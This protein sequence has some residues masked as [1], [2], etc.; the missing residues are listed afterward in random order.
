MLFVAARRMWSVRA[1]V[2]QATAPIWLP[3]S[4]SYLQLSLI[5]RV[6]F[7]VVVCCRRL[8][9]SSTTPCGAGT[10]SCG[11]SI[12]PT[13]SVPLIISIIH[14]ALARCRRV[15]ARA[16]ANVQSFQQ[17]VLLLLLLL[18]LDVINLIV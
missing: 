17:V 6:L 5:G 3:A 9:P 10:T 16:L 15:V 7:A 11:H 18:V 13:P 8:V 1:V 14:H 4:Y 2:N 12:G